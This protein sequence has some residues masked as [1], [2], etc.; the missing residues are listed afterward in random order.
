MSWWQRR[1]VQFLKKR[2]HLLSWS[3]IH[4]FCFIFTILNEK[5][6]VIL[7]IIAN[8]IKAGTYLRPWQTSI[9]KSFAKTDFT[10]L[11]IF[12]KISI[13][14]VWK[15]LQHVEDSYAKNLHREEKTPNVWSF[16]GKHWRQFFHNNDQPFWYCCIGCEKN[17]NNHEF[18][19]IHLKDIEGG[20]TSLLKTWNV[21]G[22]SV[23]K[24]ISTLVNCFVFALTCNFG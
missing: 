15:G 22:V 23:C 21:N 18:D 2:T 19:L 13:I 9:M 6:I 16:Y 7:T 3:L 10:S 17:Q 1:L 4:H 24:F 20:L 8:V 5:F 12:T 11:T 14:D